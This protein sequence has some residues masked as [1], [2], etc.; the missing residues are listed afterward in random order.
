M[1]SRGSRRSAYCLAIVRDHPIVDGNKRIALVIALFLLDNVFELIAENGET[2]T[3]VLALSED[4]MS[5]AAFAEFPR[6]HLS[7]APTD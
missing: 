4:T 6:A 7:P 1:R 5:E 3:L 2:L